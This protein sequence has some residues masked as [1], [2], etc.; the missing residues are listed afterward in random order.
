L[1]GV[2]D[3][4]EFAMDL[5]DDA[6]GVGEDG[7]LG[8]HGVEDDDFFVGGDGLADL[9][10]DLEDAGGEGRGDAFAAFGYCGFCGFLERFGWIG[11]GEQAGFAPAFALG[12]EGGF[13]VGLEGGGFGGDGIEEALVVG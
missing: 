8:L 1:A 5:L 6:V 4:A 2:D 3:G 9:D 7:D 11:Y 12:V 13:L 10:E